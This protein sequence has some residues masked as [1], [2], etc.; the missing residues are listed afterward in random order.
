MGLFSLLNHYKLEQIQFTPS[1]EGK[2]KPNDEM[3]FGNKT[4]TWGEIDRWSFDD[5]TNMGTPPDYNRYT[6]FTLAESFQLFFII[7]FLQFLA[8]YMVKLTKSD[9]FRES[10]KLDKLIHATENI[11]IAYPFQDFDFLNGSAGEHRKRFKEV[12]KEVILTMM[13]NLVFNILLL[14]PLWYTGKYKLN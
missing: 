4:F 9:K 5:N 6:L 1:K 8:V 7:I 10:N 2:L 11:N 3:K 14:G 13:V 12:N